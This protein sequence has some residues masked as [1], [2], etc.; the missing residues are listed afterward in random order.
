ML[1]APAR[2]L[3]LAG[4]LLATAAAPAWADVRPL[5]S[6]VGPVAGQDAFVI[7]SCG[8]SGS[9]AG[10]SQSG[11]SLA[12][13][14]ATPNLAA[15][16]VATE[17]A[18]AYSPLAPTTLRRTGLW[19]SDFPTDLGGVAQQE[20]DQAELRFSAAP[21][22]TI[23]R[24]RYYRMLQTPADDDWHA[25][26]G[27]TSGAAPDACDGGATAPACSIGSDA[28]TPDDPQPADPS[29]SYRDI[30]GASASGFLV[31][32][33]CRY[34]PL[35]DHTCAPGQSDDAAVA[36]VWSAFFTISDPSPP[37]LAEPT[38]AGWSDDRWTAGDTLPLSVTATDT[39]GISAID[40]YADGSLL[41]TVQ[42]PCAYDRP[43]PCD[44][45]FDVAVGLPVAGLS[46]GT[47]AIAV[48]AVNAAGTETRL[49]RAAD[50][51]VDHDA[52]TAPVALDAPQPTSA[53][54]SFA[55][56][57]SLPAQSAAPI[58]AAR[59]QL[60]PVGGGCGPVEAA[61]TTTA[62]G[63]LDLPTA[64]TYTLRVWLVD[65]AGNA[66]PAAAAT[67]L[68]TYAPA[69]EA[70][71]P[72]PDPGPGIP[73]AAPA[74]DT[75]APVAVATP[76]AP[77]RA[78]ALALTSLRRVGRRVTVAGEASP[79]ASGVVTIAYRVRIAGHTRTLRR[80][81]ALHGGRFSVSFT[82]SP[83]LAKAATA[84]VRVGYG[85]DDDT[86][87]ETRVATLRTDAPAARR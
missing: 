47:H 72:D 34:D 73:D 78:A 63:P 19:V 8:E 6:D 16:R 1:P 65:A 87:R 27:L 46:D 24:V 48:G 74:D 81:A 36:A 20:F 4:A 52:P 80:A 69:P 26:I 64:D 39:T 28:W 79:A 11:S 2:T 55:A 84:T 41:T 18:P 57:W 42:R 49:A 68:L 53:T 33:D 30:T 60:C 29:S 54:N 10:W 17:C 71:T 58:A 31:S 9:T 61:A 59:Y 23:S 85:G 86:R 5:P 76:A 40:V 56:S 13:G 35:G 44:N 22:T 32:L 67:T 25:W 7:Q 21:G 82:L 45:A 50:L 66:D 15:T 77:R 70:D 62:T 37:W 83:A 75:P 3:A 43:Q 38:G 14:T 51:Q 12:L